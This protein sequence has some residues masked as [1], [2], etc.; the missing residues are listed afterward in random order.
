M[1]NLEEECGGYKK[2]C[3]PYNTTLVY[4]QELPAYDKNNLEVAVNFYFNRLEKYSIDSIM[5]LFCERACSK[6]R[7]TFFKEPFT[8]KFMFDAYSNAFNEMNFKTRP[9]EKQLCADIKNFMGNIMNLERMGKLNLAIRKY[10]RGRPFDE[11]E[12][13][14]LEDVF[15]QRENK[16]IEN[17]INAVADTKGFRAMVESGKNR[18]LLYD[19]RSFKKYRKD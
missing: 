6:E 13:K 4:C 17:L 18:R 19:F 16:F 11:D 10:C 3:K 2:F 15:G 7:E 12:I 8:L 1:L 14:V 5:D 9:G